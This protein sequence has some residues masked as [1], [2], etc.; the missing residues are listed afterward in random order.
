MAGLALSTNNTIAKSS[1]KGISKLMGNVQHSVSRW[2]FNKYPLEELI[3]TI[4]E[5]GFSAIDCP[6]LDTAGFGAE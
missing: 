6:V 1:L 3:T 2:C 4:K 5:I